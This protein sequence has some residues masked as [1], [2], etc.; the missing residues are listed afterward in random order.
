MYIRP[1]DA[2]LNGR[3]IALDESTDVEIEIRTIEPEDREAIIELIKRDLGDYDALDHEENMN[4]LEPNRIGDLYR[5]PKGQFWVAVSEGAIVGTG[6]MKRVDD[7]ICQ[8]KRF[9]VNPDFRKH[10]VAQKIL[11]IAEEHAIEAGFRRAVTETT[12]KQK[13]AQMFF[14]TAGYTE[15]KRSM[16]DKTVVIAFEKSF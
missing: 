13:P 1:R 15:Y 7:R 3:R 5:D 4:D 2:I 11:E 16:R 9:S 14:V 10:D 8:M 6:A 12:V